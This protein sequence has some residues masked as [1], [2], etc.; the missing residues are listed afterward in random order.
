MKAYQFNESSGL[1]EGEIYEDSDTVKYISGVT[2]IAPPEY[3]AGQVAIFD[4]ARQSWEL[5]PLSIVRQ[6]LL[7]NC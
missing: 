4:A 7:K 2:S 3:E 1:Y 6:R 5:L